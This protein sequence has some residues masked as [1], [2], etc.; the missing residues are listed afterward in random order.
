VPL[1]DELRADVAF[2]NAVKHLG[3]PNA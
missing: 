2:N 3:L 1:S